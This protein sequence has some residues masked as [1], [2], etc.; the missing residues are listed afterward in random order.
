MHNLYYNVKG[1]GF[2]CPECA[3][4][5]ESR[6][7]ESVSG[8]KFILSE[9]ALRY[10]HAVTFLSAKE[11]R[12]MPLDKLSY[13]QIKAIVFTLAENVSQGVLNTIKTGMGIL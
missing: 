2:G 8:Q 9:T 12:N 10:L 1:N 6:T 7:G 11:S 5:R 13:E 3:F 4:A